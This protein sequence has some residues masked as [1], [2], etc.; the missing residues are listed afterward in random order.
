MCGSSEPDP[1]SFTA[2]S[3]QGQR[4][5]DDPGEHPVGALRHRGRGHSTRDGHEQRE[6]RVDVASRRNR[7]FI[8]LRGQPDAYLLGEGAHG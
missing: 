4:K 3:P 7:E 8:E 1:T 6:D 5:G 2:R